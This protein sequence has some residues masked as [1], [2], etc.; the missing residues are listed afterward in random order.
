VASIQKR[1]DGRYRARYRDPSGR[2]HARHFARK[3]DAQ[4]WLDEA[5]AAIV[6]GQYVDPRAGRV[7]FRQYAEQWRATAPHG[8]T[9]TYLVAHALEKHV[10]P[11]LADLPISAVR[12]TQVQSLVTAW[13]ATLAPSTVRVTYGYVVAVFGAAVRDRVIAAS[14]CEGV[15]LPATRP[16]QVEILPLSVLDALR[17]ALPPR[18]R[19]VVDLVAGSGLRQGEVFGLELDG[20]DFLRTRAVDVHQQLI[21]LPNQAPYLGRV[22]TAESARVVPLAAVTLETLAAHLAAFPVRPVTIIDR[23]D[24]HKPVQREARLVFTL[25]NGQPVSRHAWAH[26]WRP[27]ARAAELAPRT[28]LHALRHLYASLLIR[29]GESVK[30]LQ[31][32]MGHSS[33]AITLDTYAHV[34]P[35][36]DDR[37]R[38]AVQRALLSDP[39]DSARTGEV[40]S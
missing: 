13:G 4:R 9:T 34:W 11:G 33:A 36:A 22:K 1:P 18:L 3:V 26:L 30:T 32:R 14:P 28:G 16:Q 38:E 27:A 19:A 21:T 31:K 15:R 8:P 6:T 40:S 20:L 17:E 39:A 35:D 23:T 12:T 7:T 5:T 10:Y 29:H 25:L 2:E 37:T 24:P